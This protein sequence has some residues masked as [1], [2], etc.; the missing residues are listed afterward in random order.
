VSEPTN[1]GECGAGLPRGRTIC[2]SCGW[3]L[4]TTVSRP[5]RPSLLAV[6]RGGAW[7][8]IVLALIA[9]IPVVGF[10]RLQTT[11][12]GPDLATTLRWLVV[13]DDGRAAELVTINRAHEIAGAAA[14]FAIDELAPP[15]F[16]GDWVKVIDPYATMWV[17]GYMPLWSFYATTETAPASVRE[18]FEVRAADGWGRRYRI[19]TRELPRTTAWDEDEQVAADLAAG[20]R[21]NF[22]ELAPSPFDGGSDWLRL[23]IR[24]AGRDGS[25]DTDD[26]LLFVSYMPVAF[27][28]HLSRLDTARMEREL[29]EAYTLGTNY[30]RLEGSRWDLIEARLL[31]EFRFNAMR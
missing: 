5:P 13:G 29:E 27:T 16:D 26:D 18:F 28:I 8:L 15:S 30:F 24:S 4:T 1:C 23:E 11:G 25:Y 14:R 22:Y 10:I 21:T 9:A 6:L 20:L 2:P 31:A 7:R 17:R 3:D 19:T 12:P